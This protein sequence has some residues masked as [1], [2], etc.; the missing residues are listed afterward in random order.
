MP[1]QTII[2]CGVVTIEIETG[3]HDAGLDP[4]LAHQLMPK[5]VVAKDVNGASSLTCLIERRDNHMTLKPHPPGYSG[6]KLW[7]KLSVDK[8]MQILKEVLRMLNTL[9]VPSLQLTVL[10]EQIF[11]YIQLN[12]CDEKIG[13]TFTH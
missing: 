10:D 7:G 5:P 11:V 3:S 4:Q 1:Y 2:R 9:Q 6:G 8:T 13:K 12:F